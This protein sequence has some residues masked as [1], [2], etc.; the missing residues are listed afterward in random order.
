MIKMQ[1]E[2][3]LN[4]KTNTKSKKKIEELQKRLD[5]GI[6]INQINY[7]N[8][9]DRHIAKT[10]KQLM[11]RM[12]EDIKNNS[13]FEDKE[14]ADDYIHESLYMLMPDIIEWVND[15]NTENNE[16]KEFKAKFSKDEITGRGFVFDNKNKTIKEYTTNH[17]GI[18]IRKNN[19]NH[20]TGFDLVT[21]YPC[22]TEI[23]IQ[24]TGKDL[25]P[26]VKETEVYNNAS[27]I[28]KTYMLYQTD[29]ESKK[30]VT[31]NKGDYENDDMLQMN[32]ESGTPNIEHI[33]RIKENS[34]KLKTQEGSNPIETKYTDLQNKLFPRNK[35]ALTVDLNNKKLHD[36]FANDYPEDM[37]VIDKIKSYININSGTP[38]NYEKYVSA[39]K[40]I[41]ENIDTKETAADQLDY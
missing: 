3:S 35:P 30:L 14:Q 28:K 20:L 40:N 39:S 21:A 33:I 15:I 18:V 34:C 38:L 19:N 6:L 8:H 24:P 22:M 36:A 11:T 17:T 5:D 7:M 41:I 9:I 12:Y 4:P 25:K 13:T 32:I 16:T 23:G 10:D 37:K 31:F 2:K 29:P 27:P 26:I 1:F